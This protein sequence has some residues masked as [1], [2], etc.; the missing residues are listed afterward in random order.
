MKQFNELV[1]VSDNFYPDYT[2]GA[3][4]T[5]EAILE[6]FDGTIKRIKSKDV[7][8]LTIAMNRKKLWLFTNIDK[9]DKSLL[10]VIAKNLTYFTIEYDFK[11]CKL[12][13]P[14]KHIYLDRSKPTPI[15]SIVNFIDDAKGV[16][17]MS[18]EQMLETINHVGRA[19]RAPA[20][21]IGSCFRKETLNH[22]ETLCTQ[23]HERTN[24]WLIFYGESWVKGT[25]TATERAVSRGYEYEF[26]EKMKHRDVLA[27]LRKSHGLVY[28]PNGGDTCPRLVIEAKLLG[29]ELELNENVMHK[30]EPWFNQDANQ[31]MNYLRMRPAVFWHR[32]N[33]LLEKESKDVHLSE[34]ENRQKIQS[35][36]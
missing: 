19:Y 10:G 28:T 29:C 2:G 16:F 3:E 13:S 26:V 12:R 17:F 22:I 23:E 24:K 32:A 31:V 6:G 25:N 18:H 4:M 11:F 34:Q 30:D 27:K 21:V 5:T 36:N 20:F 14:D 8:Y 35:V 7:N 1:V 33:Q 15:G 9:I